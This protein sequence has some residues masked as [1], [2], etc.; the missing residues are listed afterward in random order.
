MQYFKDDSAVITYD[1]SFDM[2]LIIWD[3]KFITHAQYQKVNTALL[4]L[5]LERNC[6]RLVCD[7]TN[8][9]V[10]PMESQQW[11]KDELSPMYIQSSLQFTA[12]VTSKDVFNKV[13]MNNIVRKS[14]NT[15][16]N[17]IFFAN[18]PEALTWIKKQEVTKIVM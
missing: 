8:M 2:A 3:V 1:E 13:A 16:Y 17:S 5:I 10:L 14:N 15:H 18:Y 11:T 9:G 7:T 4:Q 6:T 12:I